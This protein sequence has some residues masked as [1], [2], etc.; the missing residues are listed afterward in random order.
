MPAEE[1]N[2]LQVNPAAALAI[3]C[4]RTGRIDQHQHSL[5]SI[6]SDVS[7]TH[8][9][10]FPVI[11]RR[12]AGKL[13]PFEKIFRKTPLPEYKKP[14]QDR[15]CLVRTIIIRYETAVSTPYRVISAA[16]TNSRNNGCGLFGRDLS[17]GCACVATNHGWFF[18]SII[19]TRLS[20]GSVPAM[21]RPFPDSS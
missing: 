2:V 16:R 21:I 18:T 9:P 8:P 12:T 10:F 6:V 17:S 20:S 1:W 19:S 13:L 7:D 3:K 15:F 5:L 4:Y 14:G 11:I